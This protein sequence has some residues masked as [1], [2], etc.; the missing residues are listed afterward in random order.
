M[1]RAQV[2]RLSHKDLLL[3]LNKFEQQYGMSSASFYAKFD[4]GEMGDSPDFIEWAGLYEW[5]T[6]QKL[7]SG[8]V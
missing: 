2:Q 3:E 6:K 8:K 4:S 1:V 5:S 7:R